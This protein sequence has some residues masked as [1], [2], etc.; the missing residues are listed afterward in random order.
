MALLTWA[1]RNA[2]FVMAFGCV[3]AIFLPS[4]SAFLRPA[5]PVLVAMVLAMAVAR[6]DLLPLARTALR[7]RRLLRMIG[8]VILLMPVTGAIYLM[9]ARLVLPMEDQAALVL[10]AAAPPI[11]SATGLA[12]LLGFAAP[13]ALEL[14][15]IA[16]V[17]TPV[18]GP[19][20]VAVL[21]PEFAPISGMTLALRLAVVIA[22]GFAWGIAIRW[23]AGRGRIDRHKQIFDGVAACGM[24]LF[25]FPLF[26]GVGAMVLAD[27]GHALRAVLLAFLF[28]TGTMLV[29]MF[30]LR[31]RVPP[32]DAGTLGMVWGNRTIAIYLAVLPPDPA[33]T[34]FVALYQFPMYF[35]PL[36]VGQMRSR[37]KGHFP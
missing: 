26:D 28:N 10:L 7:P 13:L 3:A 33:F 14:T 16:T 21:L 22:G 18:I 11:A 19:L 9:L 5:L 20:M 32:D 2:R 12:L 34:L 30:A 1:G 36:I 25:V 24:V 27:P 8:I 4:L 35:T 31:Q 6:V 23:V 15:V 37:M 29:M 17:L